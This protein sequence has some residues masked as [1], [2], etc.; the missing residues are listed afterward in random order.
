[1]LDELNWFIMQYV[2]CLYLRSGGY[3]KV[4]AS[5]FRFEIRDAVHC[6]KLYGDRPSLDAQAKTGINWHQKLMFEKHLDPRH[7]LGPQC[8]DVLVTFENIFFLNS[9]M[10]KLLITVLIQLSLVRWLQQIRII[11]IPV[12]L[13]LGLTINPAVFL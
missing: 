13:S 3:N 7:H 4:I 9:N 6:R 5:T 8:S 10:N 12:L 2:L 11:S 1:M